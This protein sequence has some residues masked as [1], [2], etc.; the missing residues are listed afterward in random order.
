MDGHGH[1]IGCAL[2]DCLLRLINLDLAHLCWCLVGLSW[3]PRDTTERHAHVV[4]LPDQP[5]I[6]SGNE[7]LM[8]DAR[9]C[10]TRRQVAITAPR[11]STPFQAAA[12]VSTLQRVTPMANC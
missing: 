2:I 12:L 1:S 6:D 7:W 11:E 3:H 8:I 10:A 4:S 9:H 5:V